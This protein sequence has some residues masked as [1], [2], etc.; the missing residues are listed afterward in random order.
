MKVQIHAI[1]ETFCVSIR[2]AANAEVDGFDRAVHP[3][4]PEIVR[5]G[6][7]SLGVTQESADVVRPSAMDGFIGV[8]G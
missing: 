8:P 2:R 7:T 3:T 6:M 1:T 5:S 4:S